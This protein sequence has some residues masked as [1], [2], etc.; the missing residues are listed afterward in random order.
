MFLQTKGGP[1]LGELWVKTTGDREQ[2]GEGAQHEPGG[3]AHAWLPDEELSCT[4]GELK[5]TSNDSEGFI[6][7]DE[8]ALE[9]VEA[10]LHPETLKR[11]R[12]SLHIRGLSPALSWPA[13]LP[14]HFCSSSTPHAPTTQGLTGAQGRGAGVGGPTLGQ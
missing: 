6:L 10:V 7:P 8:S 4:V 12:D 1:P 2:V 5:Y 14:S 9:K 11:Q 3:P 13:F